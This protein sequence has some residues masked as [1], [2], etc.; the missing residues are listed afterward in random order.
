M[1]FFSDFFR[2]II[3]D[4]CS[5]LIQLPTVAKLINKIILPT[6]LFCCTSSSWTQTAPPQKNKKNKHKK[7]P[8]TNVLNMKHYKTFHVIITS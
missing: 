2:R 1:N 3:T 5:K 8:L 7:K 4:N 6:E